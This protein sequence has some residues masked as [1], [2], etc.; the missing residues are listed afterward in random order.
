MERG[1]YKHIVWVEDFDNN[2]PNIGNMPSEEEWDEKDGLEDSKNHDSDISY[3]F[4]N[5]YSNSVKLFDNVKDALKFIDNNINFFDCVVLDVNLTKTLDKEKE[6]KE[7]L[8]EKGIRINEEKDIG[9]YCGYYI[10][11]Y[12]LKS[13]F[14]TERICIFTG[15]KGENNSTEKWEKVFHNAGIVPPKSINRKDIEELQKWID[16][17]YINTYYST[18]CTVY[19]ACE[20]WKAW[21]KDIKRKNNIAFNQ[22]YYSKDDDEKSS[23]EPDIFINMLNRVEMLYPI[24]MPPNCKAVYYQALQV[25]TSFHEES[26]KIQNIK[27]DSEIKR[28]HQA[29][30]NY[31]NW[32]AHNKFKSSEINEEVFIYMFY[33]TLR[34]YF[35]EVDKQFYIDDNDK[36]IDC[37]ENYEKD[38]FEKYGNVSID[39]IKFKEKYKEYFNRHLDKVQKSLKL[40]NKKDRIPVICKCKNI[41]DLLLNSGNVNTSDIN[42]KMCFSDLF[43]NIIDNLISQKAKF[44]QNDTTDGWEYKVTY[45]WDYEGIN[46]DKNYSSCDIF[47]YVSYRIFEEF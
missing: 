12:L 39:T 18:R 43:L 9:K 8:E 28:Y 13:G 33:V 6:L 14:P 40:E 26:A 19:K 41:N 22:I 1:I 15:N 3:V 23:I 44:E 27:D 17:C 24:N 31:R 47:K 34:T 36:D 2:N 30:R 45:Y 21:L 20:Y 38:F 10:Y 37:Y 7:T 16:S 35:K 42:E 46:L 25:V 29:V 32:S 5:K 11:L 4:G